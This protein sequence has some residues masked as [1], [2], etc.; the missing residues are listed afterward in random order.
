[1]TCN[2]KAEDHAGSLA[3]IIGKEIS[4]VTKLFGKRKIITTIDKTSYYVEQRTGLH[5]PRK[6]EGGRC[7]VK[8]KNITM[9]VVIFKF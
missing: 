7:P 8:K 2:H 9:T 4:R 6:I 3:K 1:M 5:T